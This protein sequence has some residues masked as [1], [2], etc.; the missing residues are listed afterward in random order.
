MS[1]RLL[2]LSEFN[3]PFLDVSSFRSSLL[4]DEALKQVNRIDNMLLDWRTKPSSCDSNGKELR[5]IRSRLNA[6]ED[7]SGCF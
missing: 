3:D 1:F 6:M 4:C 5:E 2:C 7:V